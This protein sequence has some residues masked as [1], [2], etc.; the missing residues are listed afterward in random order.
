MKGEVVGK[1][2]RISGDRLV[3]IERRDAVEPGKVGI[4]QDAR[5][6]GDEDTSLDLIGG[7]NF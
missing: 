3:Q 2:V 5:T 7:E 6:A 4:E 1:A